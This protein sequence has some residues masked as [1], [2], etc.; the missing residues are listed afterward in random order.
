MSATLRSFY[1]DNVG[2][3]SSGQTKSFGFEISPAFNLNWAVEQTTMS[4]G[5][6]YSFIYYEKKPP[7]FADKED[8]THSFKAM[9]NHAF[10]ERYALN[11]QDSFVVGQEADL[12]RAGSTFTTFQRI[13]GNNIRNYGAITL[14][15][16]M[17]RLFG[18]ELGY[19]NTFFDYDDEG[20]TVFSPSRSGLLD[21]IEHKFHIDGRW[22]VQPQTVG[23]LGYAYRQVDY[24]AN[25]PIGLGFDP[26]T[27]FVVFRSDSRNSRSH[28]G[29]L[30]ADH[31]FRPDLTGSV[32]IGARYTE[33]PNEPGNS[34]DIGPSVSANLVYT[35]MLESTAQI[36]ISHDINTSDLFSA[37]GNSITTDAESTVIYGSINHRIMPGLFGNVTAQFQN[38]TLNGGTFNNDSERYYLIGLNLEY[39]FN[40]NL[41]AHVGYNYDK[42]DSEVNNRSFDRNRVYLGVTASY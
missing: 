4:L 16:E 39:R 29:Y 27:G 32:R 21:R 18:V 33:Y 10:S 34:T 40:P 42:L 24:T 7:G 8:Q 36:G 25:E 11:V 17:T 26:A 1:D 5:Y 15:A 31:S 9:L 20:G 19:D 41:S 28:Y 13:P 14:N 6:V 2:T 22:K 3:V 12:L 30:G 37:Q 23:V 38:S 35:Y